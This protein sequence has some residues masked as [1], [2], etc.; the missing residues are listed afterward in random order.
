MIFTEASISH[1]WGAGKITGQISLNS[2]KISIQ[3]EISQEGAG[4]LKPFFSWNFSLFFCHQKEAQEQQ[5][6]EEAER[7]E[8][9][10]LERVQREENERLERKKVFHSFVSVIFTYLTADCQL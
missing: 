6:Q 5:V 3:I 7:K 1:W 10:R 4:H 2:P 9:E 8:K